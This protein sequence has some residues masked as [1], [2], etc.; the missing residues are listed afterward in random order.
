MLLL[1]L[2]HVNCAMPVHTFVAHKSLGGC[3]CTCMCVIV[4]AFDISNFNMASHTGSKSVSLL[5]WQFLPQALIGHL[6]GELEG[7]EGLSQPIRGRL[8]PLLPPSQL[9]LCHFLSAV[10]RSARTSYGRLVCCLLGPY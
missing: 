10:P 4:C 9:F 2:L 1:L 5:T 6:L 8:C 7:L 3:V